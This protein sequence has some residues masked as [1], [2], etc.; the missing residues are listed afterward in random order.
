MEEKRGRGRPKGSTNKTKKMSATEVETFIKLSIKKI[1]AEHLSWKDY[2]KWCTN[3]GL[4]QARANEYWKRS[5]TTIRERYDLDKEKQITK[6][7]LKYWSLYDNAVDKGDI[8]NAR[9]TLDAIA[10][11]MGLNE[12][13]KVDMNASGEINFKFGDE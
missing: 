13:D 10:K 8:T 9:Q 11:L 7:L 2:C 1:M 4:S 12:P 6:H 3:N 5:W